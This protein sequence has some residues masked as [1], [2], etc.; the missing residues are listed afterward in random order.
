MVNDGLY[1]NKMAIGAIYRSELAEGLARLGYGI[2]RSARR[3]GGSRS[4]TYHGA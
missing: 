2:E 3:T 4:R 1:R